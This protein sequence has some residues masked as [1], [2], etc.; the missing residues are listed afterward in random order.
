MNPEIGQKYLDIF[1]QE[2][3][4]IE[5]PHYHKSKIFSY[6]QQHA[7]DGYIQLPNQYLLTAV[8]I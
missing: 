8:K 3:S 1:D 6:I 5:K 2:L 7:T 4:Y